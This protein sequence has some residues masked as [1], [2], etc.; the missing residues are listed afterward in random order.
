MRNEQRA[1]GRIPSTVQQLTACAALIATGLTACRPGSAEVNSSNPAVPL[2]GSSANTT[3]GM[4]RG[5][6]AHTGVYPATAGPALGGIALAL[7]EV[8]TVSST[9]STG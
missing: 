2:S 4:F 3:G 1:A 7:A 9:R 8:A 6:P 5:D